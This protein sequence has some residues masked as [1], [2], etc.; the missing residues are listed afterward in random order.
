M[1]RW[2]KLDLRKKQINQNSPSCEVSNDLTKS[3][4]KRHLNY[5]NFHE[6]LG[7]F[8]DI[9]VNVSIG[10]FGPYVRLGDY[11]VS[12]KKED[13]PYTVTYDRAVELI[14]EKRKAQ[15]EKIIMTFDEDPTVQV[16][17]GRWGPYIAFGDRNIRIP[18]DTDPKSFTLESIR[19]LAEKT[20]I[21][22]KGKGGW[23]RKA[24]PK[25]EFKPAKKKA[26]K[27]SPAKA[28]AADKEPVIK[29]AAAKKPSVTKAAG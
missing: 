23:K 22:S 11:F 24:A 14:H 17:N 29:K 18:K 4:L 5:L 15:A 7:T 12:M 2:L 20:P 10:R 25:T 19:E 26:A 9:D 21:T 27:K 16:L 3:L 8:E 1:V 13:D 28:K 6:I